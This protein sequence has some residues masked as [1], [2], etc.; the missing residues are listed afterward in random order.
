MAMLA[1]RQSRS[2]SR[3]RR[4]AGDA[5]RSRRDGATTPATAPSC[6]GNPCLAVSRTTGFQV[7]VGS[8]HEPADDAAQG[9]IVAWTITLSKPSAT[10]IKYFNEQRGRRRR[11]RHRD[12]AR[13]QPQARTST[14][15]LVAQS[16][17]VQ[18]RNL[19]RQDRAV[20]ARNDDR[21][22][23]GRR[24]RADRAHLGAGAGARLR[25]RRPPG[26]RSRAEEA[27]QDTSTQT[28]STQ[29]GSPIQYACQ[30]QTARLTYSATLISTP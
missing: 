24:R 14:Y 8:T 7:K 28:T 19:L 23:E 20:R 15:K 17:L 4:L 5:D 22:Q 6:P 16:P 2:R 1:A 25:Q 12:P 3:C 18:A 30:Y 29:L 21:S 26:A 10:Q 13:R 9:T 11:S 27:V